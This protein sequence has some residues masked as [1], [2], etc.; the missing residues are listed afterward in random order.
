MDKVILSRKGSAVDVVSGIKDRKGGELSVSLAYNAR[1][2]A[3]IGT[4]PVLPAVTRPIQIVEPPNVVRIQ[5]FYHN[6][7]IEDSV[8]E[9]WCIKATQVLSFSS[10][11]TLS[12]VKQRFRGGD[13][14]FISQVRYTA[15]RLLH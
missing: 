14:S 1:T 8:N 13:L 3:K 2:K 4:L 15:I 5:P 11:I 6:N 10:K 9:D 7:A 12:E